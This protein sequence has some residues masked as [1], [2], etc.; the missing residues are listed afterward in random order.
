MS[1]PEPADKSFWPR[2]AASAAVFRD[3]E[4]LLVQRGRGAALGRWSLPGGKIEPGETAAAAAIREVKE[5]TT[6]DVQLIGL[7]DVHDVINRGPDGA[8]SAHYVLTVFYGTAPTGEPIGQTDAAVARFVSLTELDDY[9]LTDSTARIIREG[10]R[11]FTSRPS[12]AI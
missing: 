5:E 11:R 3:D 2:A 7:L 6:I 9:T 10:Y 8:L 1:L 12:A 4:V